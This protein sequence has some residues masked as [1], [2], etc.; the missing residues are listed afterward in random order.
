MPARCAGYCAEH[1][2]TVREAPAEYEHCF[3][4]DTV[5]EAM[6]ERALLLAQLEQFYRC[7]LLSPRFGEISTTVLF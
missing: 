6:L 1:A 7:G 5:S 2:G 4:A 3:E